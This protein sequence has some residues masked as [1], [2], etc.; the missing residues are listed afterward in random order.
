MRSGV[1]AVA[2]LLVSAANLLAADWPTWR[3]D[4]ARSAASPDGIAPNPTLLWSRKL[5]PVR[6]AWPLEVHQRLNFDASYEP[7]VMGKLASFR[8][9]W[10]HTTS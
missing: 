4:A 7:V 6:Q 3:Y 10:W 9:R 5:P 1:L 2:L 8:S